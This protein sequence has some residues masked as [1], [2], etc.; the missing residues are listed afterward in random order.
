MSAIPFVTLD[1][2]RYGEAVQVAPLV[3]RVIAKNPSKFTY[4]GTGTYIVGDGDVA[5]IDPGPTARRP[6]RRAG[7]RAGRRRVSGRSS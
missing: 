7:G 1:E 5:V 3:R 6:P 4:R 2:P